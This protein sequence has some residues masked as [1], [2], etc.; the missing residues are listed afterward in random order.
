M[1]NGAIYLNDA[2]LP[3]KMINYYEAFPNNAFMGVVFYGVYQIADWI[4]S[5][6]HVLLVF[7]NLLLAQVAA[8]LVWRLVKYL[9]NRDWLAVLAWL[10]F[11][12]LI[13]AS[14]WLSVPY[15]DTVML[16]VSILMV[17]CYIHRSKWRY[18]PYVKWAVI[19]VLSAIGVAVNPR[20]LQL[21]SR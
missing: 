5:N 11:N 21:L 8:Y 17:Y 7:D 18:Y 15:S 10:M 14:Y 6:G 2:N 4:G 3:N 16:C 20:L 1:D 19:G 9:T 13:G 12:V